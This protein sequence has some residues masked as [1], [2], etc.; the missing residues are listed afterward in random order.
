MSNSLVTVGIPTYNRPELLARAL[1][2]ICNQSYKNLQIIVSDKA[3]TD[4]AVRDVVSDFMTTRRPWVWS[5]SSIIPNSRSKNAS[6]GKL[7]ITVA[8]DGHLK[9]RRQ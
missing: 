5:Y 3:S 8:L 6:G 2:L 1:D 4:L 7:M 9:R